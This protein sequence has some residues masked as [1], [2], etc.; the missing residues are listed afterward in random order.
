MMQPPAPSLT[1]FVLFKPPALIPTVVAVTITLGGGVCRRICVEADD[2]KAVTMEGVE[3]S[4]KRVEDGLGDVKFEDGL[5]GTTGFR[6]D[7][8]PTPG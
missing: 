7:I 1:P 4:V 8:V 5:G 3:V 6:S 2:G